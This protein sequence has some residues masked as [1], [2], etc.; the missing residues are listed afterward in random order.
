MRTLV[1]ALLCF[2]LS[3]DDPPQKPDDLEI[4]VVDRLDPFT[5]KIGQVGPMA[6]VAEGNWV[7]QLRIESVEGEKDLFLTPLTSRL[8]DR[9]RFRLKGEPTKGLVDGDFYSMKGIY[10]VTGTT[11]VL[12]ETRFQLEPAS[13]KVIEKVTEFKRS[14]AEAAKRAAD[15]QQKQAEAKAAEKTKADAVIAKANREKAAAQKLRFARS[16]LMEGKNDQA[17]KWLKEIVD[18]YKDTPSYKEAKELLDKLPS[19]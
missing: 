13:D 2:V 8:A 12:G 6:Q 19:P 3:Q 5:F 17:R 15:L 4:V 16:S 10:M 18:G 11:K 14:K 9:Y 1:A 7:L